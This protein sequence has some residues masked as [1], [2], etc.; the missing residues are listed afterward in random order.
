[1]KFF[2]I[3]SL[4]LI[5]ALSVAGCNKGPSDDTIIV[6]TS[7]DNPPYEYIENEK[8]IGFDIDLANA[9]AEEM[10]KKIL[11]KNM[12]F[13]ALIPA[14][15]SGHVDMIIAGI[16]TNEV[17]AEQVDFSD[18][19]ATSSVSVLTLKDKGINRVEDLSGKKV[20]VQLGTTWETIAKGL[21]DRI[22]NMEISSINNN[23]VL[24]EELKN[25]NIDAI[26]LEDLQVKK[27][28]QQNPSFV[29]FAIE[30]AE[31]SFAI[32]FTKGS[33]LK[34]KVNEVVTTLK[35]KGKIHE[36]KEK[37][38]LNA[39]AVDNATPSVEAI[40]P[41]KVEEKALE[42][43]PANNTSEAP[44]EAPTQQPAAVGNPS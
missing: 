40:E 41:V 26:I 13:S 33:E 3:I 32:A 21:A 12:E 6:G 30:N 28:E 24:I 17:R 43:A 19:Y 23:L 37:W 22:A 7:A 31:S 20:G 1:M 29:G 10:G 35:T 42:G 18:A 34:D 11:I 8:V 14:L 25:G 27:F 4:G 16:S 15:N 39:G 38:L 5:C 2:K 36:L 9:I 44:N